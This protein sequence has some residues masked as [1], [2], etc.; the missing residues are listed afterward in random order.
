MPRRTRTRTPKSVETI[1]HQDSKRRNL[2]SAE[3][4]RL[5]QDDEQHPIRIA[6]ERRNPDLD[7]QLV[8]RG[9]D[10]AD[11]S[12]LVV[13][14]PPI[15]IQERVHPKV[16]MDDLMKQTVARQESGSEG[17]QRNFANLYSPTSTDF[18]LKRRKLSSTSTTQTGLTE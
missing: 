12:E 14:A 15:Y 5:M 1:T 16:L 9:K 10:R 11:L 4:Q 7:P 13:N 6:F 18:H 17:T 8:W 3:H 2:P